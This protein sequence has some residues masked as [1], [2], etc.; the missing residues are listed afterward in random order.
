[1]KLPRGLDTPCSGDE[2]R[3][4]CNFVWKTFSTVGCLVV[5]TK[6]GCGKDEEGVGLTQNGR[7]DWTERTV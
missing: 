2:K 7:V 5:R 1:M 4:K 6:S 3:R